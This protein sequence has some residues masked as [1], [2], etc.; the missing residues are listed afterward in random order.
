MSVKYFFLAHPDDFICAVGLQ[1]AEERF[2]SVV[3]YYLNSIYPARKSG[4][5]KKPYNPVIGET[6]RCRWT[7]PGSKPSDQKTQAGPFPG[8]DY[9]QVFSD[10]SILLLICLKDHNHLV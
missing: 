5:A 1:S 9:N 7:I 8:S 6:F 4:V 10:S 3:R 2:I